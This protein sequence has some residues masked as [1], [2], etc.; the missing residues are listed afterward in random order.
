MAFPSDIVLTDRTF[1]SVVT[2]PR[3]TVRSRAEA[4]L[5][6]PESLTISHEVAK[7]GK[8]SSVVYREDLTVLPCGADACSTT[9][10]TS[11]VRAQF[12][13]SYNPK[14]GDVNLDAALDDVIADLIVFLSDTSNIA[15]LINQEH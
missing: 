10:Q 1:M 13:I 15:K 9:A 11:A 3:S 8:I 5:L 2:T 7:N 6:N 12:K 4:D 14:M